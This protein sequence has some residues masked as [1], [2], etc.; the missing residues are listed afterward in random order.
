MKDTIFKVV[1]EERKSLEQVHAKEREIWKIEHDKD[2][3]NV[4]LA[5]QEALQEQRK[6]SQETLKIAMAEE[7]KRSKRAVEEA[8][9]RTRNELMEYVKEQ[10]RL[11]QVIRQRSLSSL[12]LFLSCAQKQLSFLIS[13]EP[14]STE[15]GEY[16]KLTST[17]SG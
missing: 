6:I 11:D 3:E 14:A 9:R 1:E 10:K 15:G 8:V 17:D 5:I 7:Q 2:Q 13:E 16:E 12:E 4:S